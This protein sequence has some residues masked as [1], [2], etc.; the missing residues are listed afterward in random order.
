[1]T[2]PLRYA[3]YALAAVLMVP[4]V[5]GLVDAWC[6]TL[7]GRTMSSVEWGEGRVWVAWMFAAIGFVS[8]LPT[9]GMTE[10]G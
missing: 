7:L 6:W 10:R 8:L 1:M 9:I 3:L 4:A 2:R 5:V